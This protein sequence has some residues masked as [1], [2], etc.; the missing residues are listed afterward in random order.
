M[1]DSRTI[2]LTKE[3]WGANYAAADSIKRRFGLPPL[4]GVGTVMIAEA[5]PERFS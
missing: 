2:R 3:I 1:V 5:K 4:R